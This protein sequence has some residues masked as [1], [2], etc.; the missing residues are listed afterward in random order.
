M[1]NDPVF[2]LI[3]KMKIQNADKRLK[4][5]HYRETSGYKKAVK[6]FERIVKNP[7]T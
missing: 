2:G 5:K 4:E 1:I 6:K 3:N 7:Q